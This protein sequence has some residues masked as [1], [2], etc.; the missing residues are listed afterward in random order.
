MA[1]EAVMKFAR[2][3]WDYHTV[4]QELPNVVDLLLVTGSH[5][6]RVAKCSAKLFKRIDARV[7]VASGGF[8]KITSETHTEP[9]GERFKR[10]M[11]A[12]GVPDD[13]ILT[14]VTAS[15]T[16]DNVTRTRTLLEARGFETKTAIIVSKPYMSRRA[17]ATAQ[18]Q[19]PEPSW[20]VASPEIAFDDYSTDDVPEQRMI[21]L[22]VGDLQRIKLYGDRGFQVP[23][24]IPADVWD[25]YERLVEFGYDRQVIKE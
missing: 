6:D 14:E 24:Q 20:W 23:Q 9:E 5:D 18:K 17:L 7:V 13:T 8:G 10:I 3:L 2:V 16:G 11:E 12:N 1:A 22:M 4:R 19:W 25:A 15:N 21:E